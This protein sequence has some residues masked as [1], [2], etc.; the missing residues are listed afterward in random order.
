LENILRKL[1]IRNRVEA[2]IYALTS[3][4]CPRGPAPGCPLDTCWE[5]I[6]LSG[7]KWAV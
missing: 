7:D 3:I 4:G 1:H 5:E 6:N 2:A